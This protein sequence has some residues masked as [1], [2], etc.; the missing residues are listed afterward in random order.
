MAMTKAER[1]RFAALENDLA[2]SRAFRRTEEV[3]PD[4]PVPDNGS[5]GKTYGFRAHA[6]GAIEYKADA[7]ASTS[8][9]NHS[10]YEGKRCGGSQRGVPLCSTRERALRVVRNQLENNFAQ[11]LARL[12]AEIEAERANPTPH[13]EQAK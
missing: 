9:G 12:D 7:H 6:Y 4:L 2:E 11:A 1:E 3:K 13:P 10:Y 5:G 8:I